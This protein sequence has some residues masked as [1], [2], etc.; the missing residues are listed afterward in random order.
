[1]PAG[2]KR[3]FANEAQERHVDEVY[4]KT[5]VGSIVPLKGQ[6]LEDFMTL[7]RPT[8]AFIHNNNGPSLAAY[9]NDSYKKYLALPPDK[10]KQ[11]R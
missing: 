7:F 4:T 9:I 6:Q 1:M 8:Y 3:F 11:E 5:Y 10:R 2:F